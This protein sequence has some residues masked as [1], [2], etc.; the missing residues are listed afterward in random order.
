MGS[1]E[2]LCMKKIDRNELVCLLI[3]TLKL[4]I[5][6]DQVLFDAPLFG[7]DHP[8]SL[9]LDSIDGLEIGLAIKK[10]Y[11]VVIDTKNKDISTIFASTN[12]LARY[13][14]SQST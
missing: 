12:A 8:S 4:D 5:S 13:I 11:N 1:K 14:E 7:Y 2:S 9:G 6:P 10:K 3:D